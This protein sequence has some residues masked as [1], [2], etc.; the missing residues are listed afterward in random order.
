MILKKF[1]LFTVYE[2]YLYH[3]IYH[4]NTNESCKIE[5]KTLKHVMQIIQNRTC[6]A[7]SLSVCIRHQIDTK[8]REFGYIQG[9]WSKKE[10]MDVFTS[11]FICKHV[12]LVILNAIWH[13]FPK[14]RQ[15][16][17]TGTGITLIY[18]DK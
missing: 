18:T 11:Q 2:Y 17:T 6:L 15:A 7:I 10:G 16:S 13:L 3:F 12:S 8:Q 4:L 9:N 1:N 14:H 5:S